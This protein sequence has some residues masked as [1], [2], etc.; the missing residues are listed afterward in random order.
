MEYD[1]HI[2]RLKLWNFRSFATSDADLDALIGP[3]PVDVVLEPETSVFI[4][5]NG[6]G[7][8]ALLQALLRLFGETR[9]ER[10]VQAAD[11]FVPPGER[12]E[13]EPLRQLWI[14]AVL[15]FPELEGED[16]DAE[17]TVPPAFRHMVVE[18][19][20]A[21]P[22]VRIRLE[23]TWQLAGTLD[24]VVEEALYW[25]LGAGD[26][27]FGDGDPLTKKRVSA[28]ERGNV[29]V[30]YIPAS[31]DITALT[32][33]TVRSLGR[34]LM[35]AIRWEKKEEIDA[36]IADASATLDQEGA[37][38]R[39]NAAINACW[40]ELNTAETGTFARLSVLA[41]DLQQIVRAA[42]ITLTPSATGRIMS[43]DELSDGQR[44][45]FHFA[46]VKA[47]LDLR[48]A[49][50]SEVAAGMTPPFQA[51]FARAPALT[52]FAFEEPENHLSP[53]FLSRLLSELELLTSTKRVQGVVT[54][55]APAIVGRVEPTAIR[56]VRR[57][58]ATGISCVTKLALPLDGTDA[59]KF[60]REAVRA[61]PEIY[62]ARH[63][64]FGEGP[65]E[66][67]VIPRIA[68][69]LGVPIDR[70]FVAIVPIG[71]RH[72]QHFWRL[73]EQL[74]I[75]HTTLLDLDLGRSTGDDLQIKAAANALRESGRALNDTE[76]G[77]VTK[78]L[79]NSRPSIVAGKKFDM[80]FMVNWSTAFESQ[81]IF[82]SEPLDL[83]MLM[84][85][86]FPEAYKKLPSGSHGPQT[87][88]DTTRQVAA[89][90]R[91]LGEGGLGLV[92]FADQPEMA[93]FPWYAYLFLGAR[94]KPAV[95]LA[96][97]GE[98]DDPS[99][100]AACPPVL[101]RLIDHVRA[102]LAAPVA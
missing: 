89:G 76:V 36:L 3:I 25:I 83:D 31:R 81:G 7:K 43:V 68:E 77:N 13:S 48:L 54:S 85:K 57:V 66:E 2:E 55:H 90:A 52:V 14:E 26:P 102:S 62:F 28:S 84:L 10:S 17:R 12:L 97:L 33:L 5:R 94:G 22:Y 58:H 6:A 88:D 21:P 37:L 20:G 95:H 73:V 30:R 101:R 46:L 50:E 4:G 32:Q 78:A 98:L 44:S 59:A 63:A 27:P 56:H 74:G 15:R 92:P 80:A 38:T 87:P 47:L 61:H 39:V 91:V 40:S 69:A 35:R 23:A 82:M 42:T 64:I 75:P 72:I 93:L 49:L 79:A 41:P 24:G 11:F 51:E 53:F 34:S 16:A 19:E 8:S 45:L 100:Q 67:I 1:V 9:E 65:S 96:A 60:V 18:S 29:L 70:S 99:I 71:G 86:A